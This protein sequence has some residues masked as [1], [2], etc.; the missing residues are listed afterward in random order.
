MH[1]A[2]MSTYVNKNCDLPPNVASLLMHF[3]VYTRDSSS[4][5][6]CTITA[7]V[8]NAQDSTYNMLLML[9][10]AYSDLCD[11]LHSAALTAAALPCMNITT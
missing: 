3:R 8:Q 7:L 10:I 5:T 2:A 1:L 4:R 11:L 6:S 9:V